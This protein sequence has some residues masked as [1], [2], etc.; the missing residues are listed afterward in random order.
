MDPTL[1]AVTDA[2][3]E[4]C[5][6][7]FSLIVTA[8]IGQGDLNL[9]REKGEKKVFQKKKKILGEF[10]NCRT[11]LSKGNDETCRGII[12]CFD[13]TASNSLWS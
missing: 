10:E 1:I 7:I 5:L 3:N 12:N 2:N 4:T 11:S 13:S 8:K 6:A 9:L